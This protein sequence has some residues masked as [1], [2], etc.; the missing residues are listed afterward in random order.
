MEKL[1]LYKRLRVHYRMFIRKRVDYR[2]TF[3]DLSDD[4]VFSIDYLALIVLAAAIATLG[5]IMNNAAVIIGAM[6]ISPLMAPIISSGFAFAINDSELG[7]RA[8][9]TLG[10]GII[11][12]LGMA[13]IITLLSPAKDITQEILA[14]TSPNILDLGIALLCGLAGTY[15]FT[16]N[17]NSESVVGIAISVALMPPLC[18]AGYGLAT[19]QID[20]LLGALLL[21]VTNF[22]AIF[23][24]SNLLFLALGFYRA[25]N[26][27]DQT[28]I[29][30]ER[31]KILVTA[32]MLTILAIPLFY[33]LQSS[34]AQKAL[35]K[36]VGNI[37]AEQLEIPGIS[38]ISYWKIAA[39]DEIIIQVNTISTIS[40]SQVASLESELK[41]T[42]GKDYNVRLAQVPAVYIDEQTGQTLNDY[43]ADFSRKSLG[44][45]AEEGLPASTEASVITTAGS[46]F[47]LAIDNI[48]RL[49]PQLQV[50]NLES[51]YKTGST[52]PD[53][54]IVHSDPGTPLSI[55]EF[56][57]YKQTLTGN[58]ATK[59][60]FEVVIRCSSIDRVILYFEP[61]QSD[62]LASFLEPMN[63]AAFFLRDNPSYLAD[64]TAYSDSAGTEAGNPEL[65]QARADNVR[66][67]MISA[68]SLY[69]T[70]ITATGVTEIPP[71]EQSRLD[72]GLA[73]LRRVEISFRLT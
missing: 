33:T 21:F 46:T 15:A 64:V 1:S 9:K 11:M 73:A 44:P 40:S 60:D 14:R 71:D 2:Q 65:A 58:F 56:S 72:A 66:D 25:F 38:R 50:I 67:Y 68:A 62:L 52:S 39:N 43:L 49:Y 3:T 45:V 27:L 51:I 17:K 23:V 48:A 22:S 24:V 34:L 20:I 36:T 18:A 37:L 47:P 63:E 69:P 16:L 6:I 55:A 53:A 42:T 7:T 35:E 8:A 54:I 12:A 4:V 30:K 32:V 61:G 41:S 29:Q 28:R 10:I 19:G 57:Q 31:K 70:R 59:E 5:L 26:P 13:A